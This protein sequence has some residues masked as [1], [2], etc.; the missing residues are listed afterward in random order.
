MNGSP[1]RV[2]AIG[3]HPGDVEI[4][5]GGTLAAHQAAGDRVTILT[6]SGGSVGSGARERHAEARAAAG[7][8][9]ARLIHLDFEDTRLDVAAGLIA[10]VEQAIAELRPDRVYTHSVHDRHPDHRATHESVE[11]AARGVPNVACFQSPSSTIDF[12]PDRFVDVEEYLDTKL[13]MLAAFTTQGFHDYMQADVVRAAARYWSR[14]GVG[15]FA[16]P[17]ETVRSSVGH[18]PAL[19]PL[20]E[21]AARHDRAFPDPPPLR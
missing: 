3:A 11:I 7:V 6:L 8:V 1:D 13:R 21:L 17:L 20:G 5:A 14:F 19:G 2:L 18:A 9:G 10:A 15:R 16:E 4:G 12:R